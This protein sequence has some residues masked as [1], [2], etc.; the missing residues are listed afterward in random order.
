MMNN[1]RIDRLVTR[2]GRCVGGKLADDVAKAVQ[3]MHDELDALARAVDAAKE[4]ARDYEEALDRALSERDAL[5]QKVEQLTA[6]VMNEPVIIPQSAMGPNDC[7]TPTPS[8][9]C[10]LYFAHAGEC[11]HEEEPPST[12]P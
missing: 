7:R 2:L 10:S 9:P 3:E 5:V 12:R 11:K 1:E 6:T 8:G 4:R